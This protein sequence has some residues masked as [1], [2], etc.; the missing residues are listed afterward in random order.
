MKNLALVTLIVAAA[1]TSS[2]AHS[3]IA[4]GA[5]VASSGNIVIPCSSTPS[6]GKSRMVVTSTGIVGTVCMAPN[7]AGFYPYFMLN[8]SITNPPGGA[9]GT[10]MNEGAILIFEDNNLGWDSSTLNVDDVSFTNI[11][12]PGL[13][14]P[15][16]LPGAYSSS[17]PACINLFGYDIYLY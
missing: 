4:N 14:P 7:G 11:S 2:S 1:M 12:C 17:I 16:L 13:I 6:G 15:T 8:I 9:L 5:D 3:L 10:T